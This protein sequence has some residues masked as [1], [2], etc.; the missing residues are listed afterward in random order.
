MFIPVDIGG[1]FIPDQ[2]ATVI[3]WD[4]WHVETATT[5]RTNFVDCPDVAVLAATW[6]WYNMP[7]AKW[8]QIHMDLFVMQNHL[9]G[10]FTLPKVTFSWKTLFIGKEEAT[11]FG[12]RTYLACFKINQTHLWK[13]HS[14]KV[15]FLICC[16]VHVEIRTLHLW[17]ESNSMSVKRSRV[18]NLLLLCVW[19]GANGVKL[20]AHNSE[21]KVGH[22]YYVIFTPK[23]IFLIPSRSGNAFSWRL[24]INHISS[25]FRNLWQ[26]TQATGF[27]LV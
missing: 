10:K 7:N 15:R 20:P 23:A 6:A 11:Y 4:R 26:C 27:N 16:A 19:Y 2:D 12:S 14:L 5:W 9:N 22:V 13:D 3:S 17:S 1:K 24:V 8:A 25:S 21:L 18:S